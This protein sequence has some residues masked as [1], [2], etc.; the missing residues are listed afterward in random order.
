MPQPMLVGQHVM[1]PAQKRFKL[2]TK[3]IETIA[4]VHTNFLQIKR[5]NS[6]VNNNQGFF[7]LLSN[8][9]KKKNPIGRLEIFQAIKRTELT[10]IV[11][12]Y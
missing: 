9:S 5:N 11:G 1:L 7:F 8:L 3:Q 2:F 10:K 12:Y 4:I 6:H